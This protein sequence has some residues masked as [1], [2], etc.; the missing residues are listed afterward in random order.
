MLRSWL[1]PHRGVSQEKMPAYLGFFEFVHNA[2]KR[3]RALLG[4]STHS[5]RCCGGALGAN[6]ARKIQ[7]TISKGQA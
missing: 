5:R 2:R 4:D 6:S 7:A 1:R 3:G